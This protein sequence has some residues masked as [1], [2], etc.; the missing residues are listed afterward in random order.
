MCHCLSTKENWKVMTSR[1]NAVQLC[2]EE[3]LF[4]SVRDKRQGVET[5]VVSQNAEIKKGKTK[6]TLAYVMTGLQDELYQQYQNKD[7]LS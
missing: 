7:A 5:R 3:Y 1:P 4:F 6:I 2:R